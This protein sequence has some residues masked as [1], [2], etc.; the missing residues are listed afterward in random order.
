ME[1]EYLYDIDYIQASSLKE[2]RKKVQAKLEKDWTV[3]QNPFLDT[4]QTPAMWTQM[5]LLYD[6][7]EGKDNK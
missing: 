1:E 6:Y 5:M 4:T 2:L 7:E 3:E